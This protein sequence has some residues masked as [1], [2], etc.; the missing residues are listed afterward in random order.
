[1][2]LESR[3][4]QKSKSIDDGGGWNESERIKYNDSWKC[5]DM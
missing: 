2:A 5:S 3:P 4:Y 1:M